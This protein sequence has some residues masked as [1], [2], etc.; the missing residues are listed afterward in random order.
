MT[1]MPVRHTYRLEVEDLGRTPVCLLRSPHLSV[2]G[3]LAAVAKPNNPTPLAGEIAR[4]SGRDI[5]PF[6]KTIGLRGGSVIPD[7]V[8]ALGEVGPLPVPAYADWLRDLSGDT[9]AEEIYSLWG[10]QPPRPWRIAAE[11]PRL[12]LEDA[13]RATLAAWAVLSRHWRTADLLLR[14]EEARVG[15]AAVTDSLGA[16]IGGLSARL[17]VTR[18]YIDFDA[19]CGTTHALGD[20]RLALVPMLSPGRQLIVSFD[21]ELPFIG[22][23]LP[24]SESGR[25]AASG[26]TTDRLSVLLGP[27]RAETLRALQRP[28]PMGRL[29]RQ[30]HCAPSTL[31]YHCD[32]LAGAG[33][34]QRERRAQSVVASLTDRGMRLL[35][36]MEC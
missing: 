4:A 34:I 14:R 21:A 28:Q 15:T 23:P 24:G 29:A 26:T 22:Y 10:S 33:L 32:Q 16:V 36:A 2:I 35:D 12:W 17:H 25:V 5:G 13:A 18:R 6:L 30:L 31:T 7:A 11:H 19:P 3:W 9:L 27:L 1:T 20:R 8:L